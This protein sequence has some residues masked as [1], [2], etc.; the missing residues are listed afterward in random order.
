MGERLLQPPYTRRNLHTDEYDEDY[1]EER[2]TEYRAILDEEYKLLHHSTWKRNAP[3]IDMTSWPSI[4][5]QPQQ[6]CQK[7]ASTDTA[8][9]KSV[10]TDVNHVRDGDYSIGSWADENHHESFAVETITYT[11]GADKLQDS[12]TDEELLDMQRR[13]NTNQIQVEAAWE[14]THEFGIFRD[15]DGYAKAID[16]HTLHVSRND[17]AD[18]LL[19]ANGANTMFMHQRSNPEHKATKESY[20]TAGGIDNGFIQRSR[21]TTHPSIDVDAP[22][23]VA[24]Q[25]E[26]DRRAYDFYGNRKFY[27]EEKMSMES[28]ETI[29]NLP[30]I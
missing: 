4:N 21:H 15:P 28:T 10:D 30:E 14:R 23:S 3:S 22:T 1:E 5:T 18:I 17:I 16:G 7:R 6:Q 11:P 2:A 20:D 24:R 9:Y 27:W 8:Y 12:F 25:P 26:F 13:D 19:T 29:G